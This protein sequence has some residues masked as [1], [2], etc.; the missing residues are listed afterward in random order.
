MPAYHSSQDCCIQ[1][2]WPHSRPLSTHCANGDFWALTGNSDLVSCWVIAPLSWVLVC[3]E[4]CFC[5]PR[6]CFPSPQSRLL[7]IS[8]WVQ[9]FR[10]GWITFQNRLRRNLQPP[11]S[12]RGFKSRFSKHLE[13]DEG[14]CNF[15]KLRKVGFVTYQL[16]TLNLKAWQESR[17]ETKE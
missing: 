10:S 6:V 4:F 11:W 15:P 1:S 17:S 5:L 12:L 13:T 16:V 2:P 3:T 9:V 7:S 8:K 14:S